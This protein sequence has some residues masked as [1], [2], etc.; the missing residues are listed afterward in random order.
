[1]LVN[2]LQYRKAKEKTNPSR[3]V[4]D[5][6]EAIKSNPALGNK[7]LPD[8][9]VSPTGLIS[10]LNEKFI[11]DIGTSHSII[12]SWL[13][14]SS[15]MGHP[16]GSLINAIQ[17]DHKSIINILGGIAET[18]ADHE[19][20]TRSAALKTQLLEKRLEM[21]ES[22]AAEVETSRLKTEASDYLSQKLLII[23]QSMSS[24]D[25]KALDALLKRYNTEIETKSWSEID[26]RRVKKSLEDT[27]R[28]VST[29]VRQLNTLQSAAH[30]SSLP[31]CAE[32][33][34]GIVGARAAES[35]ATDFARRSPVPAIPASTPP[36]ASRSASAPSAPIAAKPDSTPVKRISFTD[37]LHSA[38]NAAGQALTA[39]FSVDNP[40]HAG[41]ATLMAPGSHGR[42]PLARKP[43]GSAVS[44]SINGP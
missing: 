5:L 3:E 8:A 13:G 41:S 12:G 10:Q 38:T 20:G 37:F 4:R 16:A 18:Y 19:I 21:V 44:S 34:A 11:A 27:K 31:S 43:S 36:E 7:T 39:A 1:M 33:P 6:A 17:L 40:L 30:S 22:L 24:L 25:A 14:K 9:L 26:K 15:S 35:P 29:H 23:M 2:Y 42:P 32:S 28:I